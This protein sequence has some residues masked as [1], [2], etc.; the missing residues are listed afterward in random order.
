MHRTRKKDRW[1][2]QFM[3]KVKD[4]WVLLFDECIQIY[5]L[6]GWEGSAGGWTINISKAIVYLVV[7]IRTRKKD[8][9]VFQFMHKVMGWGAGC[10]WVLSFDEC[11]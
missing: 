9:W 3:H 4:G 8:R 5:G 7:Q 2:F 1:G 11:M 6:I 10:G